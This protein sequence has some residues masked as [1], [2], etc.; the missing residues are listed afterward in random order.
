MSLCRYRYA[1]GVPGKGV[2]QHIAGVAYL[3]VI[4]TLVGAALLSYA[5][6]TAETRLLRFYQ[7]ALGLFLLGIV[8]HWLF[9]VPTAFSRVLSSTSCSDE[10]ACHNDESG[11]TSKNA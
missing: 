8:L 6:S 10:E 9:C 1:L 4:G 5:T 2:H 11:E 7:S 3:D